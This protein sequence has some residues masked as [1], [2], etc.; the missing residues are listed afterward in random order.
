MRSN[1]LMK[2]CKQ[3]YIFRRSL[4]AILFILCAHN[5]SAAYMSLNLGYDRFVN[6]SLNENNASFA[7]PGANI[8]VGFNI[9]KIPIE[10]N[11][12]QSK[13][14]GIVNH[15]GQE[16]SIDSTLTNFAL[17]ALIPL[18]KRFY[19]SA[20]YVKSTAEFS[21]DEDSKFTE[22]GIRDTYELADEE[23]TGFSYGAGFSLNRNTKRQFYIEYNLINFTENSSNLSSLIIGYRH[24]IN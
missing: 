2:V 9:A 17:R 3:F 24:K 12:G 7:G 16:R 5:V 19:F 6:S 1:R 11:F 18:T 15:D 21:F 20:G 23:I 14:N 4:V 8:G 13:L 10:V 22:A